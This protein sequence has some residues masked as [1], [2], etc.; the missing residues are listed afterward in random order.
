MTLNLAE[1][2]VVKSRPS[3]SHGANFFHFPNLNSARGAYTQR[4]S[5]HGTAARDAAGVYFR[6]SIR[7]T[8][9]LVL[10]GQNAVAC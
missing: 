1:T 8:G 6:P 3:V 2:P 7:R 10:T 5:P 9:L 4:V